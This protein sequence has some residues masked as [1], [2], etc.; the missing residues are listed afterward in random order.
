MT[1]DELA[2]AVV[3]RAGGR[4]EYCRMHQALQGGVFHL[5]HVL[6]RSK[7]GPT[8]LENLAFACPTCNLRKSDRVEV[9][10][11]DVQSMV[12]LFNPRT[13]IWLQHF[14]WDGYL[15]IGLTPEGIATVVALDV[16]HP[17]HILIRGIEELLGLF[18]PGA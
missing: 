6:P 4:C 11:A 5:E 1:W 9:Q 10:G 18:P 3:A 15:M 17:R 14:R 12:K 2:R 8:T 7:G 13:Q 16:N